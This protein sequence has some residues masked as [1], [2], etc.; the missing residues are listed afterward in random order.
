MDALHAIHTRRS[1][2]KFKTTEVEDRLVE[3]IVAAGMMSPSA[4]NEQPWH[5]V[6]IKNPATLKALSTDHLYAACVSKAPMAILVCGDLTADRYQGFW[7]QDC[8]AATQN[9]LLAAHALGLA[10]AWI[11]IYPRPQRL[12]D[13][14]SVIALPEHIRPFALLPLGYPDEAKAMEVR[15]DPARIH[16]EK[17]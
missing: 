7:V 14:R 9:T 1:I 13:I 8:A 15:F 4:G 2:R 12:A 16:H 5:F 10:S 6:V 17:W 3:E 11:G